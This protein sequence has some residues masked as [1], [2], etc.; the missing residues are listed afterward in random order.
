MTQEHY[1]II[2]VLVTLAIVGEII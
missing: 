1:N 2:P